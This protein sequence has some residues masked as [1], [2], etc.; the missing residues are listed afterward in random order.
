MTSPETVAQPESRLRK[1]V[2]RNTKFL[3]ENVNLTHA[4]EGKLPGQQA[5]EGG[6]GGAMSFQKRGGLSKIDK[7]SAS[8]PKGGKGQPWNRGR[9]KQKRKGRKKRGEK[10]T[11][12]DTKHLVWKTE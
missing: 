5:T 10:E 7:Y 12:K 2:Q 1:K 9:T 8:P 11:K 4:L 6:I 3:H